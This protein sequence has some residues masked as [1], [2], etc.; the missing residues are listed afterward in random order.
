PDL[1]RVVR[2]R[3]ALCR[4]EGGEVDVRELGALE[5]LER[6]HPLPRIRPVDP[7]DLD[8]G[9]AREVAAEDLGVARL[10][11]V[12]EL[13]ADRPRELVDDLFRVDEVERAYPLLGKTG[14]LVEQRDV[15][16]DLAR[17][18]RPLHLDRNALAVGQ[19]RVVD[20]AD[21]GSGCRSLVELEEGLLDRQAELFAD[22]SLDL[23]ERNWPDVVL[24]LLQLDDDV[25]WDDVRAR[26]E[27]LAELDEGRAELLEH[28]AQAPATV[29]RR[30]CASVPVDP[31][32]EIG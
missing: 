32:E 25:G 9:I 12:V 6:K 1:G 7:R 23:S 10:G 18:V 20:L 28:L 19:Q 31:R 4:A 3:A 5:Q 22:D 15:R 17:R 26:G 13:R 11:P 29:R 16:L 30:V 14:G 21:R 8:L 24:E 2:K 27:E